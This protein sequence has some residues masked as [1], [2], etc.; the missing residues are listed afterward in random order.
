M[1]SVNKENGTDVKG[2]KRSQL[3]PKHK[4]SMMGVTRT[5]GGSVEVVT[6]LVVTASIV[7]SLSR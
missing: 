1:S 6:V 3:S 7:S 4:L 2:L 5:W